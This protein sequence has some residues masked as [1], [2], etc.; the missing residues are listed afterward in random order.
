MQSLPNEILVQI[1]KYLD[2][3]HDVS[4]VCRV[5]RRFHWL[6]SRYLYQ[7]N[8]LFRD[9]NAIIWAAKHGDE[10]TARSFLQLGVPVNKSFRQLTSPARWVS[11]ESHSGITPLHMASLRGHQSLVQ[12]FLNNGANPQARLRN[13]WT[14]LYLA[15]VSNNEKVSRTI[16]WHVPDIATHVIYSSKGLSPLHLASYLGLA[17]SVRFFLSKGIDINGLDLLENTPLHHALASGDSQLGYNPKPYT[18]SQMQHVASHDEVLETVVALMEAGADIDREGFASRTPKKLA[19]NHEDE[20]IRR[21]FGFVPKQTKQAATRR[22]KPGPVH[23]GRSWMLSN[24]AL[25]EQGL[26]SSDPFH[27]GYQLQRVKVPGLA[28]REE[29]IRNCVPGNDAPGGQNNSKDTEATAL[30][31]FPL[32]SRMCNS[33]SL[34]GLDSLKATTWSQSKTNAV[35]AN[36]IK[37]ESEDP[38]SVSSAHRHEQ[39][40][41]F[42]QLD[43]NSLENPLRLSAKNMWKGFREADVPR[44]SPTECVNAVNMAA[45][46][47]RKAKGKS[48]WQRVVLYEK[49]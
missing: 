25:E 27:Q 19:L 48:R 40:E 38:C 37:T 31:D 47:G 12:L 21:L 46:K 32:L 17:T 20:R 7:F 14:P 44:A 43:Y 3:Q 11:S 28:E 16:S 49:V 9:G 30:D 24:Q 6:F 5:D 29:V 36:L 45:Q 39:V 23:I 10:T 15:L 42:P 13:E 34:T 26:C 35:I 1:I 4:S 33:A 8:V 22:P 2:S 41:S 18:I